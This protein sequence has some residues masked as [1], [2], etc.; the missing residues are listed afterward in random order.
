MG[1]AVLTP[2]RAAALVALLPFGLLILG[3]VAVVVLAGKRSNVDT[4]ATVTPPPPPSPVTPPPTGA[5]A[6]E[7]PSPEPAIPAA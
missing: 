1:R 4:A 5:C 7:A 3:V 6:P 2:E